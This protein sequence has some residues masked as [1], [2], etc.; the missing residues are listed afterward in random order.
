MDLLLASHALTLDVEFATDNIKEFGR[1]PG[2]KL[3]QMP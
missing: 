1:V 3:A 2:L